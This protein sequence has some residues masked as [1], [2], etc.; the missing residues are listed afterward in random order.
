MKDVIKTHGIFIGNPALSHLEHIEAIKRLEEK[1]ALRRT[2]L[3]KKTYTWL[4][5]NRVLRNTSNEKVVLRMFE[6]QKRI[7]ASERWL[8]RI[9]SRY[10]RLRAR[11]ERREMRTR[12]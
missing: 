2:K 9:W 11:R 3:D 1:S 5:L 10:A 12:V 4:E 8:S 6:Q 7:G